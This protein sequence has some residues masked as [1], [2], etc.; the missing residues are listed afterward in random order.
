MKEQQ[1]Q[2]KE[3]TWKDT[4]AL[5]ERLMKADAELAVA[6]KTIEDMLKQGST[7]E[8]IR[9]KHCLGGLASALAD[10]S[11]V[12]HESVLPGSRNSFLQ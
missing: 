9:L 8:K 4:A 1:E 12:V 2:L 6:K 11:Q 10:D 3:K 7:D 5:S